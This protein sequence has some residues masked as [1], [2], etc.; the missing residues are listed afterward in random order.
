[1]FDF[2][3][4]RNYLFISA[5]IEE[6]GRLIERELVRLDAADFRS[7]TSS[8]LLVCPVDVSDR[9]TLCRSVFLLFPSPGELLKDV[10]LVTLYEYCPGYQDRIQ[11]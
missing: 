2:N 9:N 5:V 6:K 10:S 3:I 7:Q 1:M 4:C 11:H 8:C